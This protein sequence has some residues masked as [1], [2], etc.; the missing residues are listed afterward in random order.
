MGAVN[1][2]SSPAHHRGAAPRRGTA[3]NLSPPRHPFWLALLG[4]LG[5]RYDPHCYEP[6]NTGPD[7]ITAFV[8]HL[9]ESRS[10]MRELLLNV[11]I[12]DGFGDGR[13]TRH[14]ATGQWRTQYRVK[15][16][17]RGDTRSQAAEHADS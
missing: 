16:P 13:I 12:E 7:A 1:E 8:N 11:S 5:S 17:H 2:S 9:C 6:L 3:P 4:F 10:P 14:H 15:L